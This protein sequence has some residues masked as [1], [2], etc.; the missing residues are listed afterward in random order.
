MDL[1]GWVG[2]NFFPS[3]TVFKIYIMFLP[4]KVFAYYFLPSDCF[5]TLKRL[6]DNVL[7]FLYPSF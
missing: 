3:T 7:I 6:L 1:Y 2:N 5:G 4:I